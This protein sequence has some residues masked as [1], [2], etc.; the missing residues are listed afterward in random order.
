MANVIRHTQWEST[1]LGPIK[2]W[3]ASLKTTVT[4]VLDAPLP[5]IV[6]WGRDLIQIYNDTYRQIV[7]DRHPTAMGQPTRDCW[8]EVWDFN[9]PIYSSIFASGKS[10]HLED[11]EYILAQSGVHVPHYFTVTYSPVRDESGTVCGVLVAVIETTRRVLAER[12]KNALLKEMRFAAHQLQTMF[13]QAPSFMALLNGPTHIFEITNAAYTRLAGRQD[14]IGKTVA[15]AIPEAESQGFVALLDQAYSTGEPYLAS[16]K[17]IAFHNTS[18]G[19][20][21]QRY[22]DFVYQPIRDTDGNVVAIFVE[23]NDVTTQHH[24]R[25]ELVRLNAALQNQVEQLEKAERRQNF[26]LALADCLQAGLDPSDVVSAACDLLGRHLDVSRVMFCEI[27][28]ENGTFFVR[29]EWL[30]DGLSSVPGRDRSLADFGMDNVALLRSGQVFACDDTATDPRTAPHAAAYATFNAQ[31]SLSIPLVK[32][33]K[34]TIVLNVHHV[35]PYHWTDEDIALTRDTAERVWSAAESARAQAELRE[36]RDKSQYIFSNM[37][38][39]FGMIDQNW[40]VVQMN[41]EGLRLGQRSAVEVIGKN[42]WDI[43]PEVRGTV[44]E[45]VYKRVRETGKSETFERCV[46][47]SPDSAVWLEVRVHRSLGGELAIFYNNI[48]DRKAVETTLQESSRQKDEFLAMLAHELRNPLAPISTAAELLVAAPLDQARMRQIGGVIKRQAA[49]MTSL[50]SD[51]LDMSRVTQGLVTLD[52]ISID[53]KTVVIDAVEQI[54][55]IFESREHQFDMHLP[56]EPIWVIADK[57]R[58]VQVLANVLS[59][60]AKYTPDNGH[61]ELDLAATEH[62][63]TLSVIDNGI[64]MS[65]ALVARAFDLFAQAERTS[66]RNQGGLGI[67]LSLV[68]SLVELHGGSVSARSDGANAGSTFSVSLPRLHTD[69]ASA[70][71]SDAIVPAENTTA[72]R[73]MVVDDNVEAADMLAMFLEAA[74]HVVV[75]EYSSR[76][77]LEQVRRLAPDV[78]LL[79]L[80]LPEMDGNALALQLALLPSMQRS[81][82]I[83]ISGYGQTQ[84]KEAAFA[85]GFDHHFTKPVDAPALMALLVEIAESKLDG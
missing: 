66:D 22:L 56:A 83:A 13:D 15:Q 50:I 4:T 69:R 72:L 38:E 51:L 73:I 19:T 76:K 20:V 78:C 41:A 17:P 29:Y 44:V 47:L 80:G 65:P 58:M 24:E 23:G 16:A 11:Q 67:G 6:L 82:L 64:G 7:G 77:A 75:V 57:D 37:T 85:A 70:S 28:E 1:S 54:R 68:K 36:E 33:G 26:Q 84:D 9:G 25:L 39:G 42:H 62:H 52:K 43:W 49:H 18:D 79:D 81:L 2:D 45:T 53:I 60:A 32:A 35:V 34:L 12:D 10:V 8:P 31:A 55:P 5:T 14:L 48:T 30:R 27:N 63:I 74:G 71:S 3:T 40:Q 61:I 59:N 21:D 46:A